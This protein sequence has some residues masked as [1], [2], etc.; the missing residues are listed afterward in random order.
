M[1]FI[2]FLFSESTKLE[3]ESLF[4]TNFTKIQFA[5]S[6]SSAKACLGELG[7]LSRGMRVSQKQFHKKL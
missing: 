2:H 1:T 5:I 6:I 4:P 3:N 7:V